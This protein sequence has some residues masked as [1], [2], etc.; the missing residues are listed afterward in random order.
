VLVAAA[1]VPVPLLLRRRAAAWSL[2]ALAPLLGIASL[3]G[4]YP[5]LAGRARGPLTRAA[6]GA[7]GAWWAL[8][9]APLLGRELLGGAGTAPAVL[10]DPATLGAALSDT[11]SA[12]DVVIAPLLTSGALLYAALWALAA[13]VLPWL[14]RGRW[15]EADLVAASIWA[16][17]LGAG[18]AAI[19]E[20]IG[21]QE[22]RGL[23]AG[24]LAAGAV[25][26]ALPHLRRVRVVEP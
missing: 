22:P 1:A 6:L 17:A 23:V 18:A 11:D 19:A 10:T 12:L 7:L 5:A 25:A 9:A 20:L 24:T 15:L 4:A 26:V 2:P 3:A 13:I 14:V 16:A 21:I 8:L